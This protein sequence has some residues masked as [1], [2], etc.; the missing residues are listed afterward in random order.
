MAN[1]KFENVTQMENVAAGEADNECNMRLVALGFRNNWLR[2]LCVPSK[3]ADS[4]DYSFV[5]FQDTG[6]SQ[7]PITR[8]A[9]QHLIDI[10]WGK[11]DA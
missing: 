1:P 11:C 8:E 2:V 9:A 6:R 4:G 3:I 5:W 7:L 10:E